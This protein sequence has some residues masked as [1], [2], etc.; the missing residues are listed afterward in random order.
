MGAGAAVAIPAAA[1]ATTATPSPDLAYPFY[2]DHQ[3]GIVTPAQDRLHFSSFDLQTASRV[4]L[5]AL[6]EGVDGGGESDD[7]GGSC[8][9]VRSHR[10]FV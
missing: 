8:R 4:E 3:A 2:G 6:P 1:R 9:T 7:S 10:W 5:V